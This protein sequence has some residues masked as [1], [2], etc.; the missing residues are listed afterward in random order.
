MHDDEPVNEIL[1]NSCGVWILL[2]QHVRGGTLYISAMQ[3]LK[4][5]Y[6]DCTKITNAVFVHIIVAKIHSLDHMDS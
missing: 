5:Y 6:Y 3:N 1:H 4:L 2:T